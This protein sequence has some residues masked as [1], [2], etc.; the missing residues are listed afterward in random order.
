MAGQNI[1]FLID[2]GAGTNVINYN[3]L[4]T[5]PQLNPIERINEHYQTADGNPL[6]I[7]GETLISATFGNIKVQF[8]AI[9]AELGGLEAIL[10][11]SFCEQYNCH[12][13]LAEGRI[14][15]AEFEI[16]LHKLVNP[17][18]AVLKL[19][20]SLTIPSE[21]ASFAMD[22]LES[23]SVFDSKWVDKGKQ[24]MFEP[25]PN[26]CKSGL[27][28]GRSLVG[29]ECGFECEF[30]SEIELE[31]EFESESDS[32]S[33][34]LEIGVLVT[35]LGGK[36]ITLPTGLLGTLTPVVDV[37]PSRRI[38]TVGLKT[39]EPLPDHLQP[40]LDNVSGNLTDTECTQVQQTLSPTELTLVT[41]GL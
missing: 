11:M 5:L 9:V 12:L 32:E 20:H 27:L 3:T 13:N 28:I 24:G 8:K 14:T 39:D 7:H 21:H 29:S 18:C 10:G 30:E 17:D 36:D 25:D 16:E 22:G 41:P 35:N 37:I 19:K 40:L 38:A 31:S 26:L 2:T 15:S 23:E 1:N 6:I 34:N 33:R 4:L